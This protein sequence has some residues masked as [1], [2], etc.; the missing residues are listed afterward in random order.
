MSLLGNWGS[1][2]LSPGGG[3]AAPASGADRRPEVGNVTGLD[4]FEQFFERIVEGT[5]MRFF[6]S[7]IQP[8]EIGR[9]LERA[10]E[11]GRVVSVGSTLVPNVYRAEMHPQDMIAFADFV[12]PLSR[13]MEGW[14]SE[15]IADRGYRTLGRVRVQ[16]AG[17]DT[18]PRRS[19]RVETQTIPADDRAPRDDDQ[20]Q[21]TEVYRV[22]RESSGVPARILRVMNGPGKDRTFTIRAAVTT[23]GRGLDNDLVL[24]STDVS[25]HHA[26]IEYQDGVYHLVDLGSTN[27]TK[28][29][30]QQLQHATLRD[31]DQIEFGSLQLQFLPFPVEAVR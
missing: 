5:I 16:I 29:N 4:R 27:G 17:N 13:Q 1:S 24:E 2:I 9:K 31:G 21:K 12:V 23:I 25:R 3:R 11:D 26:R 7:P 15:E 10:M 6:R 8:A 30:G 14:L 22:I 18:V 20:I 19:I 28:V